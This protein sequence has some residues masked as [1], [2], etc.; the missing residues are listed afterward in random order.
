[1]RWYLRRLP[2]SVARTVGNQALIDYVQ[3]L[4]K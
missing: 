2:P 1:V 3:A 4:I